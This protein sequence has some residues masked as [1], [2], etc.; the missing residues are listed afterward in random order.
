GDVQARAALGIH[1][2]TFEGLSDEPLDQPPRNLAL[3]K[4]RQQRLGPAADFFVLRHGQTWQS[5][6]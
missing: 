5:R 6:P 3:A 4:Q 1:W 2:G